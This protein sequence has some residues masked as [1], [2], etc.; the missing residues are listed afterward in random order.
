MLVHTQGKRK[1]QTMYVYIQLYARGNKKSCVAFF[2]F[3]L[4]G[5]GR[6]LGHRKHIKKRNGNALLILKEHDFF[7]F[8]GLCTQKQRLYVRAKLSIGG[9]SSEGLATEKETRLFDC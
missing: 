1:K 2:S 6:D 7:S 3:F 9:S 8:L 4:S 5:S